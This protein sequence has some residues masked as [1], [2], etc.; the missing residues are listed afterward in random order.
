M[1]KGFL[2]LLFGGEREGLRIFLLVGASKLW[3]RDFGKSRI[4]DP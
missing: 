2:V 4:R 1:D 3:P